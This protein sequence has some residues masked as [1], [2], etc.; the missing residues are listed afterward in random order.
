MVLAGLKTQMLLLLHGYWLQV[1][2]T[3]GVELTCAAMVAVGLV[4]WAVSWQTQ[5]SGRRNHSI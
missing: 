5:R 3:R 4:L 2:G 1:G